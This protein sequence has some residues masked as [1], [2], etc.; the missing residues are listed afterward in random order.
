MFITRLTHRLAS[1]SSVSCCVFNRIHPIKKWER[2]HVALHGWL[3]SGPAD[4]S[5]LSATWRK[6]Y[7]HQSLSHPACVCL[8]ILNQRETFSVC[9]SEVCLCRMTTSSERELAFF[10]CVP[11]SRVQME[12]ISLCVSLLLIK[13][14]F[15]WVAFKA[16]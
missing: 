7:I 15:I 3:V 9:C 5:Q 12:L 10:C 8:K 2:N 13:T 11:F 16:A 6:T 14:A 4:V 1:V